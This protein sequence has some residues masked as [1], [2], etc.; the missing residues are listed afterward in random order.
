MFDT[1]RLRSPYI[2]DLLANQIE[3]TSFLKQGI[4]SSTGHIQYQFTSQELKGSYDSRIHI[5]LHREEWKKSTDTKLPVLVS[6]KPYIIIECSS[7]KL[8]AGHNLFGGSSDFHFCIWQIIDFIEL[9]LNIKLPYYLDFLVDRVDFA[10]NFIFE[11]S[12]IPQRYITN[13]NLLNY[14]RRQDIQ[15]YGNNSIYILGSTTVLKF[16]YKGAE[17]IKHDRPRLKKFLNEKDIFELTSIANRILR[18]ELGFKKRKLIDLF[19][20]FKCQPL[21]SDIKTDV[22]IKEFHNHVSKFL[23]ESLNNQVKINN[24]QDVQQFLFS[25][26]DSHNAGLLYGFW[27]QIISLGEQTVKSSMKKST[28]YKYRKLLIDDNI[29]FTN[30]ATQ[31]I[32]KKIDI[33]D[34]APSM[35]SDYLFTYNLLTVNSLYN[36]YK[37][38]QILHITDFVI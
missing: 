22:I 28:F 38:N 4:E 21:V 27:L 33:N 35:S 26:Y 16:Y 23:K 24:I 37:N 19:G 15:R 36:K 29:S 10:L 31:K 8:L 9:N 3:S 34:F 6:C 13:L 32:D 20:K 11:S 7:N 18:V 12:E 25:R 30:D 5:S 14:P 17:F 2:T 1:I